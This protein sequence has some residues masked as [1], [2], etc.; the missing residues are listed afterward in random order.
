MEELE[1]LKKYLEYGVNLEIIAQPHVV[2]IDLERESSTS[3][4]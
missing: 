3:I 4:E 1:V 2:E